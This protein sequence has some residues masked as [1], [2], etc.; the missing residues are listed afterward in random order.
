MDSKAET[1]NSIPTTVMDYASAVENLSS[2]QFLGRFT[3][4]GRK[5]FAS[6][7]GAPFFAISQLAPELIDSSSI[8]LL[9]SDPA[10]SS[11]ADGGRWLSLYA[12]ALKTGGKISCTVCV[13]SKPRP[14]KAPKPIMFQP[15]QQVL[16][17]SWSKHLRDL[18][19]PPDI[20]I[21]N[22]PDGFDAIEIMA[23]SLSQLSK[24]R[25]ALVGCHSHAEALT[26]Q[27]LLQA[28]GCHVSEILG[29]GLSEGEPQNF[30]PGAWWIA[31]TPLEGEPPGRLDERGAKR[32]RVAYQ[33]FRGFILRSKSREKAGLVAALYATR[34]TESVGEEV[35]DS[36]RVSPLGGVDLATG[37]FFS[38]TTEVD[39]AGFI[40]EEKILSADLLALAP[41][42]DP[43]IPSD[44][45]R[46]HL[47][48]WLGTAMTEE[49]RREESEISEIM[50]V[51]EAGAQESHEPLEAGPTSE[52]AANPRPESVEIGAPAPAVQAVPT[53]DAAMPRQQRSRLSRNAG[54]VNVLAL[55]ALLG[56]PGQDPHIAFEAA[57]S[58]I[59]KWLS[60][61]GFAVT[62]PSSNTHVELPSGE[63][64]IETDGQ[65][66]WAMRFDDRKSME[67]GAIW[68]VEATLLGKG[69]PAISLRLVQIRSTEDAPPPVA[70]GVPS[71]VASIAKEVGLHDAGVP[72]L[73][74]AVRLAG[75]G[76]AP[77][78]TGLLLNA[79]RSQP[80]IV[81]SSKE[82]VKPDTS[83]DRLAARLAG[84]AHVVCIDSALSDRITRSFGRDRSVYG[85]AVR[86]YR[87]G[88]TAEAEQYQHSVWVLKSGQVPTWIS[89]DIF[90]E[91]CA[92]SL[93]VGDL[94]ERAPS[95]QMVRNHLS[96]QRF[97]STEQ[98]LA[99][100]RQQAENIASSK[101][102]QIDKLQAIHLELE[103]ALAEYKAK[104]IELTDQAEQ[105]GGELQSI[106]RERNEAREEVRQLRY[107]LN[108][109]W[110][111]EPPLEGHMANDSY[112][113]ETWDELEDWVD[114]YGED[115][116]VLHPQ[117][118]KAARK[119][120]FKDIQLAY[121]AME[122]L[123][124]YYIPMRTRDKDD[125]LAYQ[126]SQQALAELGLEESDVGT[127][128]DIKRYKQEYKRQ[129][130][131]R[132]VT[133]DRH[134][135]SGVGFGGDFQF[136]LYF[137]YDV[138]ATKVVI[139]HM[140][141]HL[142]NRLSHNG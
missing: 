103:S 20:L 132:E 57:K 71:V 136:R 100:L 96:E 66:V 86:L 123:V 142:T 55:A 59:L 43:A 39:E 73:N 118:A 83:V 139:G 134:L 21:V 137:Y 19:T 3:A 56:K 60:N 26:V 30:G 122:Y 95:F 138:E 24:G 70:S 76:H 13:D 78:L 54:T 27:F 7:Y 97:A 85:N 125:M 121:R 47:M 1:G 9:I 18:D 36:V 65:S 22:V 77:W 34:T 69:S 120:P 115:K 72:L 127:A 51:S 63:V 111:D 106:R 84:V 45:D 53:P 128:Q 35:I 105:L 41:K 42:E 133:L 6:L 112:Y 114:I 31:A 64:S 58:K 79:Q 16:V 44:E 68:R 80:V 94:E 5:F 14:S 75:E 109:Q 33:C 131:G 74:T 50:E 116:L 32:L 82:K 29:Y 10:G 110:V 119:S 99:T 141:T 91:A 12:K 90:E 2:G 28:H 62:N 61:K 107:Q 38:A 67:E 8:N 124:R 135:K 46:L 17:K 49:V 23:D 81:V 140:P 126:N 117:A 101:D 48:L 88:F 52:P 93:E 4:E 113:P 108:N 129:Y 87:P 104:N 25:K 102:E 11:A 40:W 130:D 92:I 98:R 37:R 89:N 15:H